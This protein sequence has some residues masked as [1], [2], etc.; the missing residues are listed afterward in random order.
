MRGLLGW[1]DRVLL[2]PWTSRLGGAQAIF[3]AG[4]L[5]AGL[6]G[7]SVTLV[8][9]FPTEWAIVT[10]AGAFSL[11]TSLLGIAVNRYRDVHQRSDDEETDD[12]D[13]RWILLSLAR[14]L[15]TARRAIE[16][17]IER[18]HYWDVSRTM[19][20]ENWRSFELH[21]AQEPAYKDLHA[22]LRQ[23]FHE[24]ARVEVLVETRDQREGSHEVREEDRLRRALRRIRAAER[25]VT[26][27]LGDGK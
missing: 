13:S 10:A 15:D 18:G 26:E 11:V 5:A 23:A 12:V 22:T 14:D 27:Q 2:H 6:V 24:I 3:A 21:L 20:K 19:P 25:A 1:A 4:V 17:S 16:N 9:G 7:G 8:F